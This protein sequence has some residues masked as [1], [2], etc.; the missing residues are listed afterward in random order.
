[1]SGIRRSFGFGVSGCWSGDASD[2]SCLE[3]LGDS[4]FFSGFELEIG[5]H[6]CW[7]QTSPL[8]QSFGLSQGMDVWQFQ[9][10]GSSRSKK[11]GERDVIVFVLLHL[12]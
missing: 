11:N 9:R 7:W 2:E 4:V 10:A 3:S 6:C 8:G 1:M 12:W 5:K